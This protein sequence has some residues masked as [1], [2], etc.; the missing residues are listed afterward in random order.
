MENNKKIDK[1]YIGTNH[2]DLLIYDRSLKLAIDELYAFIS[3]AKYDTEYTD[4]NLFEIAIKTLE[5]E[6]P[7]K[8]VKLSY[9]PL[10][11]SGWRYGCPNCGMAVG[12]NEKDL[13]YEFTQQDKYCQ[14]CGQKLD[15]S[16]IK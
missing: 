10:I 16:D 2:G 14:N 7:Q 11:K 1:V 5:K 4:L 6:I 3:S 15:W 8:P 9:Q 13:D 12:E